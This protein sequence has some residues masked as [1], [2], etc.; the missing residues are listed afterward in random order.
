MDSRAVL[1][2][3][4]LTGEKPTQGQF[5]DL[6]DSCFNLNDDAVTIAMVTGL[7]AQLA[8]ITASI[9]AMPAPV[10][11]NKISNPLLAAGQPITFFLAISANPQFNK[12]ATIIVKTPDASGKIQVRYDITPVD[13][14]TNNNGTGTF[15]GWNITGHS[16]DG[17]TLSEDMT[18]IIKQ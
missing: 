6:I 4:F 12:M 10:T 11:I 7:S 17:V 16:N 2:T 8:A 14:D 13:M 5:A 1:K 15:T 18:I 9:T 3:F